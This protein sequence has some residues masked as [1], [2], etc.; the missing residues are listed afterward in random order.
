V[1]IDDYR[2]RN[3]REFRR[4]YGREPTAVELAALGRSRRNLSDLPRYHTRFEREA[5]VREE[6]PPF[7]IVIGHNEGGNI[8]LSDGGSISIAD[9]ARTAQDTRMPVVVISCEAHSHI[10]PQNSWTAGTTRVISSAEATMITQRLLR[11]L[12]QER[13]WLRLLHNFE[14]PD[15]RGLGGLYGTRYRQYA[16]PET[17]ARLGQTPE[18]YRINTLLRNALRDSEDAV[19]YRILVRQVAPV[20]GVAVVVVTIYVYEAFFDDHR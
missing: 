13:A 17:A 12:E 9:L 3:A 2:P 8:Q 18:E 4:I 7:K 1:R 11:T 16:D 20:A 14:G 5:R 6:L 15:G 10:P 19:R